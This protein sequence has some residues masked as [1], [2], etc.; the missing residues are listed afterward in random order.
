M[1]SFPFQDK[2]H[3]PYECR[4][5]QAC[6]NRT[7][8]EFPSFPEKQDIDSGIIV[9]MQDFSGYGINSGAGGTNDNNG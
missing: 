6:F 3:H 5:N 7:G 9:R 4:G 2:R 8:Q 1:I